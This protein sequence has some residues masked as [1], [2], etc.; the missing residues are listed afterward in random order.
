FAFGTFFSERIFRPRGAR[1]PVQRVPEPF[2]ASPPRPIWV[3]AIP[4][5][6]PGCGS[7]G[8]PRGPSTTPPRPLLLLGVNL[9]G[10]TR[11]G[12][13]GYRP[14][15]ERP[16]FGA[17]CRWGFLTLLSEFRFHGPIADV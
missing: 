15:L 2:P 6:R 10:G 4:Q 1:D 7:G 12:A 16:L 14:N 8:H 5:D 3:F 13:P 17:S 9:H 11:R